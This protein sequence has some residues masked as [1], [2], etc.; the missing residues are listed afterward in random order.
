MGDL[1]S[2]DVAERAGVSQATVSRVLNGSP[3]VAEKTRRRVL[4]VIAELDYRPNAVARGLVTSRTQ[5]VG[6]VVS[7]MTNPFYPQFIEALADRLA[8]RD[9]RML[10]SRTRG[11]DEHAHVSL[12]LGQRVEGLIF[13]ATLLESPTV[14]ELVARRFPLVL[15]NRY[16][17]GVACDVVVGDNRRGAALAAEH[18][19]ELGHKR[20]AIVTGRPDTS[21][22]R[23][24]TD[25][26]VA[27]LERDAEGID[28]RLVIQ[29]DYHYDEA[30]RAGLDLLSV[31]HP[32]TAIFCENDYMALGVLNAARRLGVDVPG[33]LSI[34]G[35]DA[36][37]MA[38]WDSFRLTTVRQPQAEMAS[39]S[40]ELLHRRLEEGD[41]A[42]QRV[43]FSS[44]LVVGET[45][46]R[47]R[48]SR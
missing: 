19:I 36:I 32:P 37:A 24:R 38:S 18:L 39:T 45:T 17:D 28:P 9:L 27:V 35:F 14:R 3:R 30:V 23:D 8:E 43:V 29:A 26:F 25:G 5:M 33:R 12:L 41:R 47:A 10:F 6:L 4:A 40:V 15:A 22:C 7:D 11:T 2:W 34:I 42:P 13:M 21:T 46:A 44:D 1:T 20:I 16:V 31:K 48:G